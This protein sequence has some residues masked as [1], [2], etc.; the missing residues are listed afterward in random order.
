MKNYYFWFMGY[1]IIHCSFTCWKLLTFRV[2][3]CIIWFDLIGEEKGK[4]LEA[5]NKREEEELC[6]SWSYALF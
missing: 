5:V 2:G 1:I 6:Q 3:F 4:Y